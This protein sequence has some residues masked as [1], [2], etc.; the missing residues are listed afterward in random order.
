MTNIHEFIVYFSIAFVLFCMYVYYTNKNGDMVYVPAKEDGNQYLVRNLPDKEA[1]ADLLARLRKK[2]VKLVDY[3]QTIKDEQN[4]FCTVALEQLKRR[5]NPDRMSESPSDSEHTSYSVDKGRKI[6]FCIRNKSDGTFID[7]NTVM[8]VSTH[9]MAH[10][11]TSE[12]GHTDMFWNNFRFLL[13]AAIKSGAYQYQDFVKNPVPY[14]G[15]TINSSP[16][17]PNDDKFDSSSKNV[18]GK[19][20]SCS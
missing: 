5:F 10:I 7:E 18:L 2:M 8:Y 20:R 9:E 13:R 19:L 15:I 6:F 11:A 12:I 14:C 16:Y 4:A 3:L 1:A 17:D